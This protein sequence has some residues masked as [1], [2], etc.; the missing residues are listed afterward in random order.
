[1][2]P[3]TKTLPVATS[4]SL[5]KVVAPLAYRISPIVYEDMP[6]PP[7]AGISVPES[8]TAPVVGVL[9]RSPVVPPENDVSMDGRLVQTGSLSAPCVT[10]T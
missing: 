10:N 3:D 7:L 4:D 8:V 6:V 1:M 2:P 9:G 5:D